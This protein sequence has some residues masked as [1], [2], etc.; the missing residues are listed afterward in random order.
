MSLPFPSDPVRTG[1]PLFEALAQPYPRAFPEQE[2]C[3]RV[4]QSLAE[5]PWCRFNCFR[6]GVPDLVFTGQAHCEAVLGCLFSLTKRI[7]DHSWVIPT[8]FADFPG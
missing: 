8:M 3:E 1:R 6:P 4:I 7:E 5:K 2:V